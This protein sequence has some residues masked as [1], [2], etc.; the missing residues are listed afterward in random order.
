[1]RG[2][3]LSVSAVDLRPSSHLAETGRAATSSNAARA[4]VLSITR[5]LQGSSLEYLM[6]NGWLLLTD[7]GVAV[8]DCTLQAALQ[9]LRWIETDL[10]G[11]RP[12]LRAWDERNRAHEAAK[13]VL[14]L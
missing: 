7:G 13:Y 10:F 4:S 5:R 11:D 2:T 1:M 6:A 8:I 14:L 9:G 12:L 3:G